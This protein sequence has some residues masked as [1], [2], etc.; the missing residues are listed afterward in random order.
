M[1]HQPIDRSDGLSRLV[2]LVERFACE[3]QMNLNKLAETAYLAY[4]EQTHLP[5]IEALVNQVTGE[6]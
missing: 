6:I 4:H 3:G 2:A 1:N 5:E